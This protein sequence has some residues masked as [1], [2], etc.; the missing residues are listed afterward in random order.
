MD[1]YK[2]ELELGEVRGAVIKVVDS[3][4]KMRNYNVS[5][6]TRLMVIE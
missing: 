1:G 5:H 6:H 2:A 4:E 3:R